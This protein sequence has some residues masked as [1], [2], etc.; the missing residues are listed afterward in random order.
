MTNLG[1]KLS[2][3]EVDTMIQVCLHFYQLF[4]Y[5]LQFDQLFV[6]IFISYLFT[7]QEADEDKDGFINYEE[8]VRTILASD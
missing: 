4:V 6:Y 8:F 7:L 1:E 2:E 5:N 3:K